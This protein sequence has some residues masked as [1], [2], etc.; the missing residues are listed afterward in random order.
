[1]LTELPI[2]SMVFLA[3]NLK[4][5]KVIEAKRIYMHMNNENIPTKYII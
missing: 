3:K 4:D 1:M 2:V 5:Q